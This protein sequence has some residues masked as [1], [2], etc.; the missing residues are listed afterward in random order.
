MTLKVKIPKYHL[1]VVLTVPDNQ[2]VTVRAW[3]PKLQGTGCERAIND[4]PACS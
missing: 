1:D 4:S 2:L 3:K